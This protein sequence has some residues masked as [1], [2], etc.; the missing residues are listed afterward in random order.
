MFKTLKSSAPICVLIM[1]VLLLAGCNDSDEASSA[2]AAQSTNTHGAGTST[3]S[4]TSTNNKAANGSATLSWEAPT[5]NTNGSALTDLS[6]YRIYYGE[7]ASDLS[8]S[9]QIASVGIQTYVIENL[10]PGT[11]YFAIQALTTDGTESALSQVV[12]KTIDTAGGAAPW[13]VTE[14]DGTVTLNPAGPLTDRW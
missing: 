5:S 9:V 10:Q 4:N 8:E 12:A 13:T 3:G 2:S 14:V 11:W 7:S 1:G 6:G